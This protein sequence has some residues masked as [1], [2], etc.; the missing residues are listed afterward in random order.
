M[1]NQSELLIKC[2]SRKD[3]CK[4]IPQGASGHAPL[5][6]AGTIEEAIAMIYDRRLAS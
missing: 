2:E 4:L 6:A 1:N 3:V 5:R